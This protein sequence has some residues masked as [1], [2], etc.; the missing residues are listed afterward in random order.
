MSRSAISQPKDVRVVGL[1]YF[2][3]VYER[4][5]GTVR[6]DNTKPVI[7]LAP[8]MGTRSSLLHR[9]GSRI[10]DSLVATGYRIVFRPH[11][12]SYTADKEIIDELR[13]KY[14][15]SDDFGVEQRQ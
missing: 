1:T 14:P 12:Q 10:I 9:Y 3:T 15:E 8:S 11:P 6:P 2:D 13:R 7:L 4:L 5:A